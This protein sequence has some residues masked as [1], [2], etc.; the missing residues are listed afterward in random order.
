MAPLTTESGASVRVQ[1]STLLQWVLGITAVFLT[2]ISAWGT[3]KIVNLDNRVT[4]LEASDYTADQATIEHR[5]LVTVR[6]YDARETALREQL[7]RI[8]NKIDA[9]QA[10]ANETAARP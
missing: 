5:R 8:E 6:E 1:V 4:A 7:A 9:L 2:S 10:S 3:T